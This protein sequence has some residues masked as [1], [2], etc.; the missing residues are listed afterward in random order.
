MLDTVSKLRRNVWM[1]RCRY[2]M[3]GWM[4][5]EGGM[6]LIERSTKRN[7]ERDEDEV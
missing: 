2:W 4:K 5:V 1:D 7:R 3:D 6:D